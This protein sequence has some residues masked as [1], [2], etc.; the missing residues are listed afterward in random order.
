[1]SDGQPQYQHGEAF[2]LM[3]YACAR[4]LTR[5]HIWNSRDGV[6][7]FMLACDCGHIMYHDPVMDMRTEDYKPDPDE[8]VFVDE[9]RKKHSGGKVGS[10]RMIR[11]GDVKQRKR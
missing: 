3:T 8:L 2:M 9:H 7:P 1:M 4:C 6:T 11:W 10:P 5:K